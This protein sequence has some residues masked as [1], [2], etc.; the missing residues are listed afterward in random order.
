[1][2]KLKILEDEEPSL[3]VSYNEQN[4]QLTISVF[5]EIQLEIIKDIV[6]ER[7]GLDINFGESRPIYLETIAKPVIGYGHF[8]P[9]RHYS[10][11]HL[12]INPA[13]RGT[14]ISFKSECSLDI[15]SSNYQNLIRTH[16]FEKI[17]KGVLIGAPL[18][19]VEITL[20]TGRAHEKHTEGG[21]FREATYRAIRQGL[22]KA[23]S[24]LLE[25]WFEC[26]ICVDSSVAGHV[27]SDIIRMK[28]DI[29][30][31]ETLSDETRITANL[32]ASRALS[33]IKEFNSFTR[34]K[35][36]FCYDNSNY[37]EAPDGE[38]II[39]RFAYDPC[40]DIENTPDSV[41]CS[42]GAGHIVNWREVENNIHCK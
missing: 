14:G 30:S 40:A 8:E 19:D 33:Y 27:M 4:S 13:P 20:I 41:F 6:K 29:L 17:H 31:S 12:R 5:G 37:R 36:R 26:E 10:E 25:P 38:D 22:M 1:M 28:G 32:C 42:H 18:T 7:F 23:E 16:V 2:S 9:L 15:L 11:V 35:G 34:G 39:R 24:I 3:G 21:D